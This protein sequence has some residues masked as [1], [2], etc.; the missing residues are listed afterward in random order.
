MSDKEEQTSPHRAD[1]SPG[2]GP[3]AGLDNPGSGPR[4][5]REEPEEAPGF[6]TFY[7]KETKA[8]Q[9]RLA[10]MSVLLHI[11]WAALAV[12]LVG[13]TAD[14]IL[15]GSGFR[16]EGGL[17][18]LAWLVLTVLLWKTVS[19]EAKIGMTVVA[20][21]LLLAWPYLPP[22]DAVVRSPWSLTAP[23]IWPLA[24]VM[25][26]AAVLAGVW[27][28]WRRWIWFSI[29]LSLVV[30]YCAVAP[31]WAFL[32][33]QTGLD[34]VL[35][36]PATFLD[37]PFF[38]RPGYL[39][40]EVVLPLG[41]VLMLI[42]QV[43]TLA[44][45][46]RQTHF[47]YV[48]WAAFLLLVTVTGLSAL[49]RQGQPVL[50]TF[51]RTPSLE[52]LEPRPQLQPSQPG[53]AAPEQQGADAVKPAP[54]ESTQEPSAD[55]TQ[56]ETSPALRTPGAETQEQPASLEARIQVLEREVEALKQRLRIQEDLLQSLEPEG[57]PQTPP[58]APPIPNNPKEGTG[59]PFNRT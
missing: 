27:F 54:E 38:V 39:A 42:L 6:P 59:S 46:R 1:V 45:K 23:F 50:A 30:A 26:L 17:T 16:L 49:D 51:S 40:A 20:I 36:G 47:G 15:R 29:I 22:A 41:A 14:L 4:G 28:L 10:R 5:N 35:A 21:G 13:Q 57:A 33:Q 2:A 11:L 43:R 44:S 19:L 32:A 18:V 9:H 3:E 56:Q 58:S 8:E 53:Q 7:E 25:A 52:R 55:Q 12:V 48:F 37:W 24:L 34:N 31:V